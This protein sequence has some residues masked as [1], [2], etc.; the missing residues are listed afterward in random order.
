M[1][2]HIIYDRYTQL[3]QYHSTDQAIGDKPLS[4]N[5]LTLNTG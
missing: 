4:I 1:S 2:Q 3:S 5:M